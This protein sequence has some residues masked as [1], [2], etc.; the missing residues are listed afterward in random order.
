MNIGA[1]RIIHTEVAKIDHAIKTGSFI[2]NKALLD[3]MQQ[4]KANNSDLHLIGLISDGGV[5]STP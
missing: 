4:A 3:A 2:E 1:G 5:H